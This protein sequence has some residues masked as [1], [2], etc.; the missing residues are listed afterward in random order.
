MESHYTEPVAF[1]QYVTTVFYG[2]EGLFSGK[3]PFL[4]VRGQS[5][6]RASGFCRYE[7]VCF[8]VKDGCILEQDGAF[9]SVLLSLVVWSV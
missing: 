9:S 2:R 7:T 1:G 6:N 8:M 3:F 4:F 5:L